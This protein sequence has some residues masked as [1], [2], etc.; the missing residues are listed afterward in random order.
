M[1]DIYR[2]STP[3]L[4]FTP[5]TFTI[6][7]PKVVF[8]QGDRTLELDATVVSNKYKVTM[9]SEQTSMF[10]SG[11][12]LLARVVV[13]DQN[14]KSFYRV[15]SLSVGECTVD[16]AEEIDPDPDPQV[17]DD[18][19]HFD[20]VEPEGDENPSER[21]WY[22]IVDDEYVL[23]EDTSIA[24]DKDY[25]VD[26]AALLSVLHENIDDD[27]E[28]IQIVDIEVED[29]PFDLGWYELVAGAYVESIDENPLP[30]KTYYILDEDTRPDEYEDEYSLFAEA[31]NNDDYN[32]V[33]GIETDWED[34]IDTSD[35][36]NPWDEDDDFSREE[37]PDGFELDYVAVLPSA[38]AVPVNEAWC[39]VVDGDYVLTTDEYAVTGKTYYKMVFSI[40]DD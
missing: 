29:S 22:E 18:A 11:K 19:P 28:Y 9:T 31:F 6:G 14:G 25:F 17:L 10:V 24:V 26:V 16:F 12:P 39:E 8:T 30:G 7:T 23:S 21:G 34:D 2:G 38:G 36:P 3:T 35:N 13:E 15:H 20:F 27:P 4:T 32:R 5:V 40:G 37:D 1:S 33:S